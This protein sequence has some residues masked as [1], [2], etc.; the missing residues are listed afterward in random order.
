MGVIQGHLE[1]ASVITGG[2]TGRQEGQ[3][4]ANLKTPRCTFPARAGP[5]G[6]GPQEGRR[7][8]SRSYP[9]HRVGGACAWGQCLGPRHPHTLLTV[10]SAVTRDPAA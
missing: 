9:G 6:V 5:T 4:Q 8:E 3:S 2:V 7:C 10:E 1:G